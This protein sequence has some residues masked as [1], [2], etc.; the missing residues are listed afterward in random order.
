MLHA[1][2]VLAQAN[3]GETVGK[4]AGDMLSGLAKPVYVGVVGL[5]VLVGLMSRKYNA[6]GVFLIVALI[7]GIPIL[8]P[9]EFGNIATSV[10]R[11][12]G[13]GL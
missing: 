9:T 13:R 11:F 1:L 12:L 10:G 4:N 7:A 3:P 6:L 8:V 2:W 5:L